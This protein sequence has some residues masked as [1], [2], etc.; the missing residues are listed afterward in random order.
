MSAETY[1]PDYGQEFEVG[2]SNLMIPRGVWRVYNWDGTHVE[3]VPLLYGEPYWP[4]AISVP[5]WA[6]ARFWLMGRRATSR[7]NGSAE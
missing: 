6:A 1:Q 3:L 2:K 7:P 5:R 4:H